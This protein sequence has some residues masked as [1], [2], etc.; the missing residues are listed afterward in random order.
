MMP[1]LSNITDNPFCVF[2]WRSGLLDSK[3]AEVLIDLR[4]FI[5]ILLV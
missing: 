3:L 4:E 1:L 2:L 5:K